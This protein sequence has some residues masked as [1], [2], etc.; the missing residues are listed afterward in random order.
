[1]ESVRRALCGRR[2]LTPTTFPPARPLAPGRPRPLVAT[3]PIAVLSHLL[4]F[5]LLGGMNGKA[6]RRQLTAD[7]PCPQAEKVM[8]PVYA[9]LRERARQIVSR[10]PPAPFYTE[11]P[12]AADLSRRLLASNPVV[13]SLRTF[14]STCLSDDF[15]HGL[16][17]CTKVALDAG[18]L[19]LIE[20]PRCGWS[21]EETQRRVLVA[22]SAGLLHDTCRKE[23][24][25]AEAGA[26]FAQRVL[27]AYPFSSEEISDICMAI[28]NHE[29]FR[30]Q[31]VIDSPAGRLISDCLYDADKFRWGPDNFADTLWEMLSFLD[32]PFAVFVSRYPS[33]LAKLAGIKSTFRSPTGRQY[34]PQFIDLG[35]AIG[36]ELYKV[37]NRDFKDFL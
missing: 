16:T 34:G 35:L 21:P 36:S 15:G 13:A 30:S 3:H 24:N 7:S 2:R 22:Q 25:H 32:P 8:L 4:S 10:F 23:E 11:Q 19:M 27:E 28:R 17:H 12:A 33:G 14:V 29:A 6:G 9:R 37:I 26:I 31:L 1:M 20:G 18:A 5:L